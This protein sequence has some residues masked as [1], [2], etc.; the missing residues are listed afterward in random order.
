MRVRII[1]Y[2]TRNPQAEM[3]F[4]TLKNKVV[5]VTGGS[6]GIGEAIA[7]LL[8]E[9]GAHIVISARKDE[10]LKRVSDLIK[11][12]KGSCEYTAADVSDEKQAANLAA[13]VIKNHGRIDILVNNA[14]V[15]IYKP[16]IDSSLEDWDRVINTNLRGPFLCSKAFVPFMIKQGSGLIINIISGAGKTPMKNLSIYC[17][18]KFGLAGLTESMK[19]ELGD[20]GIKVLN[21]YPGYVKTS[22]FTN[23]PA[24]F[25]LPADAKEP[26]AVA[27]E[28]L[29]AITGR[30][31]LK[32]FG[33]RLINKLRNR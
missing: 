31:K 23:Y 33:N 18:S 13:E 27:G 17:A 1:Y 19:K 24:D 10:D 30:N 26:E 20:F 15:G 12:K 2:V 4:V 21:F 3:K 7:V 25:R 11:N 22:F 9:N 32:R 29:N 6:R 16:F 5:V 8:A 14:G 28:V